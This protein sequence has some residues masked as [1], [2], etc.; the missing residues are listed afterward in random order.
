MLI[1]VMK[2]FKNLLF[3]LTIMVGT[4]IAVSAQKDQ[5][6]KPPPK[7][8]PPV[9]KPGDKDRPKDKPPDKPKKP[10]YEA[11]VSVGAAGRISIEES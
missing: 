9:V 3:A 11:S 7:D 4:S 1:V 6:K 2:I 10:G 8:K 5:D